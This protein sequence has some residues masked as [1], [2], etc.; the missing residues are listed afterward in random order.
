MSKLSKIL[1]DL[2]AI[3]RR[4][5][6]KSLVGTACELQS[7][8]QRRLLT[9]NPIV[10]IDS[11][12]ETEGLEIFDE[13]FNNGTTT[14]LTSDDSH[15]H[16]TRAIEVT[17]GD[18]SDEISMLA[19]VYL[20]DHE[21]LSA[22]DI[23]SVEYSFSSRLPDGLPIDDVARGWGGLKQSRGFNING[24]DGFN[25]VGDQLTKYNA[26]WQGGNIPATDQWGWVNVA[27]SHDKQTEV[28]LDPTEWYTVRYFAQRNTPGEADGIFMFWLNDQLIEESTNV[29]WPGNA[30][31]WIDGVWIGGNLSL[32][33]STADEP[34]RRLIDNVYIAVNGDVPQMGG[35]DTGAVD[36]F[37]DFEGLDADCWDDH[38]TTGWS[39]LGSQSC[40]SFFEIGKGDAIRLVETDTARSGTHA[41]QITYSDQENPDDN[42][43]Q[44]VYHLSEQADYVKTTQYMRFNDTHDFAYRQKIHRLYSMGNDE[45]ANFDMVINAWGRSLD[46]R[47]ETDMTGVNG[48]RFLSLN[49][50]GG[51]D[52]LDWGTAESNDFSFERERWYKIASEVQLNTVGTSDGWVRL[53]VDDVLVAEKSNLLIRASADH[54]FNRVMFG[55]WY[56]NE[57]AGNNPSLAPAA[58]TS[59]L[60]DDVSI[61]TTPNSGNADLTLVVT[62]SNVGTRVEEGGA[63]D[64]VTIALS[65]APDEDVVINVAN[66][67]AGD[68]LVS[69]IV[70]TFTTTNWNVPQVVSINAIDDDRLEGEQQA[71]LSFSV[72]AGSDPQW[73]N[74]ADQTVDVAITDND[75]RDDQPGYQQG[76]LVVPGTASQTMQ[77]KF[78][79]FQRRGEYDNELGFFIVDDLQGGVNGLLPTNAGYAQEVLTDVSRQVIFSSGMGAGA[80]AGFSVPGGARV[81]FYMIQNAS[82]QML[83]EDNSENDFSRTPRVFFSLTEAN[84]DYFNHVLATQWSG[85]VW[86]LGWEDI[87]GGGDQS[88]TDAVVDVAVEVPNGRTEAEIDAIARQLVAEHR[89]KTTGKDFRDWG[90]RDE[91]WLWGNEG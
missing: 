42:I 36:F 54:R 29:T 15:G 48:T 77:L 57:A 70:L 14:R 24:I 23:Q 51:R 4:N 72:A 44:A 13:V 62:Q 30:E 1:L 91:R 41:L 17:Y 45:R 55:G 84:P 64:S 53:Y 22:G 3:G 60:I 83:L 20:T 63:N 67:A 9:G 76:I 33:G 31:Q 47:A 82:T 6:R 35:G 65:S 46:G 19:S 28:N 25:G 21:G 26:G 49:Y 11:D 34:F 89:L 78:D 16:G 27:G 39:H 2:F 69:P 18:Q 5:R 8:E 68:I 40:D 80:T 90:G 73:L 32:G 66:P 56:S 75:Q 7:L 79:W 10:L 52:L 86:R 59:L 87:E 37:S 71:T 61:V 58:P 74:A 12:F 50:G 88:F 38:L 43:G 85:N 81:V